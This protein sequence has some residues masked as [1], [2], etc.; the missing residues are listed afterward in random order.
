MDKDLLKLYALWMGVLCIG[1]ALSII[2]IAIMVTSL[3]H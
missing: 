2:A 1:T 3:I